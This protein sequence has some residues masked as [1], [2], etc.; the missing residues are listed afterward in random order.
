MALLSDQDR[1]TITAH[2]APIAKKVDLLLFTQ[3]IGGTESGLI[4]KQVAEAP[5]KAEA[6]PAEA[7]KKKGGC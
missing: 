1:Q 7:K 4:A 2:L 5:K 3:T 6:K